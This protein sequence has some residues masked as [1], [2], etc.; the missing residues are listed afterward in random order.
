MAIL[1]TKRKILG[2]ANDNTGV[3]VNNARVVPADQ[4]RIAM[5]NHELR[6][7][8]EKQRQNDADASIIAATL[9]AGS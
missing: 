6:K 4:N 1:R 9:Y 8:C 5:V 3:R 2:R 7:K